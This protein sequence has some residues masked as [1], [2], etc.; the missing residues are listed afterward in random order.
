MTVVSLKDVIESI[1]KGIGSFCKL[2]TAC[3]DSKEML[4]RIMSFYD[5]RSMMVLL[6]LV[7][8]AVVGS[9]FVE[10]FDEFA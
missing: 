6:L 9:V 2:R 5:G 3:S 8:I 4:M 7:R 10:V 1:V